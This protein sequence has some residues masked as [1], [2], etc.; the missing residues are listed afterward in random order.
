MMVE[1]FPLARVAPLDRPFSDHTLLEW[2]VNEGVSFG[3]YF[4]FDKSWLSK[5]GF[6]QLVEKWRTTIGTGSTTVKLKS[7]LRELK[8][9]LRAHRKGI[10]AKREQRK[11]SALAKITRLDRQEDTGHLT[12]E[13][14]EARAE[15]MRV[16]KVEDMKAK[17]S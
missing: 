7:K 10:L 12:E 8:A 16:I 13:D 2:M 9:F 14:W 6:R 11:V 15:H 1:V 17:V 5:E 3:T 4:K